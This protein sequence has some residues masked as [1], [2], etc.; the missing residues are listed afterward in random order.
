MIWEPK[1]YPAYR[2]PFPCTFFT[3]PEG[4]V[5]QT[6][7]SCVIDTRGYALWLKQTQDFTRAVSK[8]SVLRLFFMHKLIK[9]PAKGTY[10]SQLFEQWSVEFQQTHAD[11]VAYIALHLGGVLDA[12]RSKLKELMDYHSQQA[13]GGLASTRHGRAIERLQNTMTGAAVAYESSF[14]RH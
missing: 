11:H 12:C 8:P 6:A 1:F 9:T 7:V 5:N 10:K 4:S 13:R 3:E 14:H 2:L